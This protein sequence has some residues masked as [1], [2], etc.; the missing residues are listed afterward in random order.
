MNISEAS[1]VQTLLGNIAVPKGPIDKDAERAL[2]LLADRAYLA[3]GAGP[4]GDTVIRQLRQQPE[5]LEL[6]ERDR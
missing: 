4:D 2:V 3:L 5:P 6:V 1:A